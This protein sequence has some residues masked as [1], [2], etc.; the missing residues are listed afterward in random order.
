M[1][2]STNQKWL[3][4]CGGCLGVVVV[5][6]ALIIGAIAVWH[7]SSVDMVSRLM[8]KEPTGYMTIFG[9]E[10]KKIAFA[11]MV[12]PKDK[13]MLMLIKSPEDPAFDQIQKQPDT[14]DPQKLAEVQSLLERS[15]AAS[16]RSSSMDK[17]QLEAIRT[18]KVAGKPVKALDIKMSGD[19]GTVLAAL[20]VVIPTA[21]QKE[22]LLIE[23][24]LGNQ[25][26]DP[27]QDFTSVYQSMSQSMTAI[28][29]ESTLVSPAA[30]STGTPAPV[31]GKH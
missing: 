27:Q 23:M 2:L 4:G 1:A 29:S 22:I 12:S 6:I 28:L 30:P 16:S 21:D 15:N 18:L 31:S 14:K 10:D 13:D 11:M 9:V 7:Q 25:S 3:I 17:L 19:S 26:S 5:I 20:A 24:D 8:G